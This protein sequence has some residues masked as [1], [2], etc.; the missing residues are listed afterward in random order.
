VFSC[1]FFIPFSAGLIVFNFNAKTDADRSWRLLS[2]HYSVQPEI[3]FTFKV[4]DVPVLPGHAYMVGAGANG[5][6]L[7]PDGLFLFYSALASRE[8]YMIPTC[9][10]RANASHHVVE[11]AVVHALTKPGAGD[12]MAFAYANGPAP[13]PLPFNPDAICH[14][15]ELPRGSSNTEYE[16]L[17]TDLEVSEWI[18]EL[19]LIVSLQ[20]PGSF[21]CVEGL[22]L[23]VI[24]IC[25][26][27]LL[28]S[29]TTPCG[30]TWAP[31]PT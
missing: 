3:G 18:S 4:N 19:S 16:L 5:I 25:A 13:I 23:T 2:R 10:L 22:S 26:L 28:C 12:G 31:L 14:R 11:A 15:E 17:V 1:S 9:F 20:A 8:L 21:C 29:S 27:C 6:A 7:T 30:R 24:V